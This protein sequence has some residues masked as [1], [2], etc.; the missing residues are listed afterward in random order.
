MSKSQG[1]FQRDLIEKVINRGICVA[2]GACVGLCPYFKYFDGRVVVLDRCAAEAGRCIHFCPRAEHEA[3]NLR[4]PD[5]SGV[6]GIGPFLRVLTARSKRRTKGVQ[7]GGVVS[8]LAA[9]G[10]R[11]GNFEGAILTDRGGQFS[12]GGLIAL[13]AR[14]VASCSGSRYSASGSLSAFNQAIKEGRKALAVVGLPCQMEALGRMERFEGGEWASKIA[15]KIGLFCTWALDYRGLREFLNG[16]G[17]RDNVKRYD[18]PPPPADKFRVFTKDEMLEFPLNSIRPFIQKGC[19]LCGDMTA[20]WAD[21]S[22]GTFEGDEGWNTVIIRTTRGD[23]FFR[24][25]VRLGWVMEGLL[26]DA[27]LKHLTSASDN[28]RQRAFKAKEELARR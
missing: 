10:L 22:V 19:S 4:R 26:P 23:L 8:A 12:P 2:C 28:K 20:E 3:T 18:I 17:I 25:A 1:E 14:Q 9:G 11:N 15:L 24:E 21:I 13:E 5:D 6:S 27:N 7:Y 16:N